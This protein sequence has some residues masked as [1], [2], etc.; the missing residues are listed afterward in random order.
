MQERLPTGFKIEEDRLVNVA[1]KETI[2]IRNRPLAEINHSFRGLIKKLIPA[3]IS[4]HGTENVMILDVGGGQESKA[5][6][7]ISEMGV[8]VANADLLA[9]PKDRSKNL[10][11][12][13]SSV[14]NLPFKSESFH[15]LYTRQLLPYFDKARNDQA[16]KEIAR[17]SK[18][19]AIAIIDEEF[20]TH[21][22]YFDTDI[23]SLE[24]ATNSKITLYD[25]GLFL[26]FPERIQKMLDPG[27]FIPGKFLVMQKLPIDPVLDKVIKTI[28]VQLPPWKAS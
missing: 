15:F 7:Q 17:V 22:K 6:R 9:R 5:S 18:K 8:F 1:S 10:S 20:Y 19:G 2:L 13:P 4:L 23:K 12:V 25:L 11:P 21:P 3:L 27:M 24:K 28:P 16:I 26:E 14:L